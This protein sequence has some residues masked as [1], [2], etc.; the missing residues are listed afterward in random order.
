MSGHA[1]AVH[2]LFVSALG[3]S[4]NSYAAT[5]TANASSAI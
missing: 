1:A 4:A 2:E 3:A 5:E